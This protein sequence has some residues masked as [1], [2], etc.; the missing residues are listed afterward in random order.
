MELKQNVS[1]HNKFEI[2]VIRNGVV[3]QKA[4]GYNK[5]LNQFWT[6]FFSDLGNGGKYF[7]YIFY[8]SGTGTP[9]VTDTSLFY[10][11]GAVVATKTAQGEDLVT[12]G[13]AWVTK[14]IELNEQTAVG[15]ELS[16]VGIGWGSSA[17]NLCTHAMLEDMNG[18]PITIEK[19]D[20]DII[21]IYATV[22]VHFGIKK[23]VPYLLTG[24]V[25]PS[26]R[27]YCNLYNWIFGEPSDPYYTGNVIGAAVGKLAPAVQSSQPSSTSK[28]FNVR[29]PYM[30]K[31]TQEGE[32]VTDVANKRA[33]FKVGRYAV[34]EANVDGGIAY[35]WMGG[36]TSWGQDRYLTPALYIP[37]EGFLPGTD[38]TNEAVGTGDGSETEFSTKY[39]FP[40]NAT[41][42]VNGVQVSN[43]T[44]SD[45]PASTLSCAYYFLPI[46]HESTLQHIIPVQK[47]V[48]LNT[49]SGNDYVYLRNGWML[50]NRA[51]GVGINKITKS[52]DHGVVYGSNDLENWTI[53]ADLA[54][55]TVTL[56]GASQHYKYFKIESD[57]DNYGASLYI[58]TN[59]GKNI[60]FTT[61]PA[62][63]AVITADYH[64]PYIA[65]DSDHVLD[66]TVVYQ[67]G[68]YTE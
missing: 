65:K 43:Y 7:W 40:T 24:A 16:E 58:N 50:Y 44:I 1:I 6:R 37:V 38:I 29:S 66:V 21:N 15:V 61:P 51:Y 49:N 5:I 57:A 54:D 27:S 32:V 35:I 25:G 11:E 46:A 67:F 4:V 47:V 22:Y 56:T 10:H 60:V 33:T 23:W 48:E 30:L 52:A 9:S 59:T 42:R 28:A 45:V 2:E 31:Y 26:D 20:V 8:G 17:S 53:L 64:T 13:I 68:E 19:T 34:A 36:A 62:N 18:N 12:N 3:V 55:N 39:D 41:I 14:K 63:G